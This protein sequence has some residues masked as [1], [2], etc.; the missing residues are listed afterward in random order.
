M[1]PRIQK[2]YRD[3]DALESGA[4]SNPDEKRMVGHYW[5]RAPDLAPNPEISLRIKNTF[6]SIKDFVRDVHQGK[7]VA[8][9]GNSF[10]GL[11]LIGIGGSALGTQFVSSALRTSKD[12]DNSLFF[13]QYRSRRN[14]RGF[15]PR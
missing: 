5:L 9:N 6:R 1:E 10:S 8:S 4:I 2:A 3:M 14:G 12:P 7:I 13:R 11:L 15:W